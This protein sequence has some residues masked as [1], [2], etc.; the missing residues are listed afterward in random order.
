MGSILLRRTQKLDRV[1]LADLRR[2]LSVCFPF[3]GGLIV[4]CL[5]ITSLLLEVIFIFSR[6]ERGGEVAR[7]K[8]KSP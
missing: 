5:H 1:L 8:I 4:I 7:N 3:Y 2:L 6:T